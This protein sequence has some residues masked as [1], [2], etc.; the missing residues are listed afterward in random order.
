MLRGKGGEEAQEREKDFGV[1]ME[2]N[3]CFGRKI[4]KVWMEE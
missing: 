1:D 4:E 3:G 2:R